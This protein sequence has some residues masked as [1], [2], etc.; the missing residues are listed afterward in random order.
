MNISNV[1]IGTWAM[2]EWRRFE[3]E[4]SDFD[5]GSKR[6]KQTT[7]SHG[8]RASVTGKVHAKHRSGFRCVPKDDPPHGLRRVGSVALWL[9]CSDFDG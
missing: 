5:G 8:K 1:V 9:F 6:P 2:S 4:D 7:I 3:V